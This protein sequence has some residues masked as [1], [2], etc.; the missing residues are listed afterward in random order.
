MRTLNRTIGFEEDIVAFKRWV[1]ELDSAVTAAEYASFHSLRAAR[2]G[3]TLQMRREKAVKQS[4]SCIFLFPFLRLTS[5]LP[6]DALPEPLA[7]RRPLRPSLPQLPQYSANNSHRL[8]LP[9]SP[10]RLPLSLLPPA[11]ARARLPLPSKPKV[12]L[13]QVQLTRPF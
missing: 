6:A 10:S 1:N 3:L 12:G 4:V 11:P 8:P 13:L 5:I 2:A 9:T 7:Y